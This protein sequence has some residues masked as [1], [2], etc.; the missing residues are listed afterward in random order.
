MW[1]TFVGAEPKRFLPEKIAAGQRRTPEF[2]D[3]FDNQI[4]SR[5]MTDERFHR[6]VVHGVG[7]VSHQGDIHPLI[8]HLPN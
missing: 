5:E 8:D 6:R 1:G 3:V 7:H 2:L 4:I